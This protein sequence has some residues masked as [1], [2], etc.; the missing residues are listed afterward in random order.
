M[1][2]VICA[3]H[4]EVDLQWDEMPEIFD[5]FRTPDER[6]YELPPELAGALERTQVTLSF[7]MW[8]GILHTVHEP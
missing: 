1:A 2:L 3:V 4:D 7:M 5:Y 6:R 8:P